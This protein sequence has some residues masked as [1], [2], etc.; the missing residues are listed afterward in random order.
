V[1]LV[2]ALEKGYKHAAKAFIWQW[3]FPAKQLTYLPKPEE[4]RRYHV[5]AT[6]L[7]KAIKGAIEKA[8]INKR[9]SAHRFRHSFASHLLQANY[10]TS[11][12][13]RSYWD[14]AMSERR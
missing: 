9:A 4:Y 12:R 3:F 1:I 5:H 10:V 6:H 8:K 14:T 7:Q 13:F 2:N 11:G